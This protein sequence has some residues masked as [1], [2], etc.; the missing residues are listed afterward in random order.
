MSGK[1]EVTGDT[2][3]GCLTLIVVVFI[4]GA[5]ALALVIAEVL[6]K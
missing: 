3:P 5:T 4:G 1:R 2:D 6:S